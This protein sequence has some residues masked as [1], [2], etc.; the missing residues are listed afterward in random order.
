MEKLRYLSIT[1]FLTCHFVCFAQTTVPSKKY[2]ED[3][4]YWEPLEYYENK[5]CDEG[6]VNALDE[7]WCA[8]P[9]SHEAIIKSGLLLVEK[10]GNTYGY[11]CAGCQ[12][13]FMAQRNNPVDIESYNK[14]VDLIFSGAIRG[15]RW[16]CNS[17]WSHFLV[18]GESK[19]RKTNEIMYP[20][21]YQRSA[22]YGD[23][24]IEGY[25]DILYPRKFERWQVRNDSTCFISHPDA[26][27]KIGAIKSASLYGVYK[28]LML[29]TSY[30]FMDRS[31]SGE[32][33][34]YLILA[35]EQ[36][37]AAINEGVGYLLY[38]MFIRNHRLA[39]S[40]CRVIEKYDCTIRS[41]SAR[42]ILPVVIGLVHSE[43]S[44][45]HPNCGEKSFLND[46]DFLCSKRKL[47]RLLDTKYGMARYYDK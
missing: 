31:L 13:M 17:L 35:L 15:D 9:F 43:W 5:V 44:A 1:I 25:S 16:C 12:Y 40:T 36:N 14:G 7:M 29:E 37:D 45:S 34:A 24:E 11:W 2:L 32:D 6:D 26:L 21:F 22:F 33:M 46:F 23:G 39:H 19:L 3:F 18:I 27:L 42:E 10:W 8:Y 38:Q 4:A 47:H 41:E 20:Y 28:H 30:H